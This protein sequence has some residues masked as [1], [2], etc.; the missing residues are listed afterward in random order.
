[1]LFRSLP[2]LMLLVSGIAMLFGASSIEAIFAAQ[3][4]FAA[5]ATG[6]AQHIMPLTVEYPWLIIAVFG[7]LIVIGLLW[8]MMLRYVHSNHPRIYYRLIR[9]RI[10]QDWSAALSVFIAL[11][12]SG[13]SAVGAAKI[14]AK[15]AEAP[16]IRACFEAASI[17]AKRDGV[18]YS[19]AFLSVKG[20]IPF[21]LYD[22]LLDADHI[23]GKA[24]QRL[25]KGR[26]LCRKTVEKW[27]VRVKTWAPRLTQAI[28]FSVFAM[29]LV[30]ILYSYSMSQVA[31]LLS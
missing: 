15:K 10:W 5:K 27:Q 30:D 1:M 11:Q 29:F 4:S 7:A 13:V 12:K 18:R 21:D 17:G 20:A 23:P 24:E 28:G 9:W 14:L 22:Y 31:S 25:T 3:N 2:G 6:H 26:D 19:V 8:D 16:L